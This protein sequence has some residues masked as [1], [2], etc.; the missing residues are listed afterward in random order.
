MTYDYAE[1]LKKAGRNCRTKEDLVKR[2][3]REIIRTERKLKLKP[4][5]LFRQQDYLKRLEGTVFAVMNRQFK[6]QDPYN[7]E[8]GELLDKLS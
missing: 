7:N 4:P 1:F 8:L 2:T 3:D 5:L 6:Y